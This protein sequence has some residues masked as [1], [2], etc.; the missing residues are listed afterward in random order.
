MANGP[1]VMYNAQAAHAFSAGIQCRHCID[2]MEKQAVAQ[3]AE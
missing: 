3:S 2:T 1:A